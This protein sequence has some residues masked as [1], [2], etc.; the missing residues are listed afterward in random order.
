MEARDFRDKRYCG[1]PMRMPMEASAWKL[2]LS[3][4]HWKPPLIALLVGL[5]GYGLLQ[6]VVRKL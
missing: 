1:M 4:A 2:R 6:W 3:W 5:L